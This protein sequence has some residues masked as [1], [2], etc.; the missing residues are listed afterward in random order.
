MSTEPAIAAPV[1]S[2]DQLRA[3][4][5]RR[6]ASGQRFAGLVGTATPAGLRLTVPVARPGGIDLLD[7]E[8]PA[9]AATYP[10]LTPD[11]PAAF[12]YERALHDLFG[13]VPVGHPRLDPLVL[14]LLDDALRP[15]PGS[16]AYPEAVVPSEAALPRLVGGAGVFTIPHGPVRS[17]VFESVEYVVET[18]GEDIPLVSVRPFAKHR[19]VQARFEGMDAID[20]VLLAERIE[21]IASVAHA[22]AYAHGVE[23]IAGVTVPP[24]ARLVRVVHAELERVANHLDVALRLAEAA[25]LAVAVA[26]FGWHKERTLRLI[27]DMCGSRFGRGVVVPGGVRGLPLL[28]PAETRQRIDDL[29][30]RPAGDVTALME[31]PSFLDRLRNTGPLDGG[32]ADRHGALGP[33][34]RA[35][36]LDEDGRW[37]RPYDAYPPLERRPPAAR[38]TGDALA[39]LRVR[40][41]EVTAAFELIRQA[42]DL[43][44]RADAGPPAAPV[45]GVDGRAVGWAEAPQGEV[46]Y[47]VSAAGGRLTRCAPRSASFHN[48]AL[49]SATFTGDIL[50]DFPFNEASFGLSI[51]GVVL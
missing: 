31:T 35:S 39:R 25:G 21:G 32:L 4:L 50:T 45:S 48:L 2:L 11:V 41:D 3:E 6:V 13:V 37:D 23:A 43:L 7:A 22:L 42:L 12:W 46:L 34:G 26:R 47:V 16:G 19:G 5:L 38:P 33:V 1:G 51:A 28:S 27:G 20:A 29:A 49:F 14:P 40:W 10:S 18:P 8:L 17:A 24:A 44:D 36:G 9:G 30:G 15:R